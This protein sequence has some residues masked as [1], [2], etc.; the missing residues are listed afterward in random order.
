[1]R[2]LKPDPGELVD[3]QT[4]LELKIKHADSGETE[5]AADEKEVEGG[6]VARTVVK[7]N[8]K[9]DIQ[10]FLWE[11]E[12]IQR[13]MEKNWFPDFPHIGEEYDE[14][15]DSLAEVN[16]RLWDL[17]DEARALRAATKNPA[18][19]NRAGIVLFEI[20]EENDKRAELVKKINALFN[21]HSQEKMYAA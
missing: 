9:V 5:T 7:G 8:S 1:M 2:M 6:A 14:L 3:R 12:E 11:N 16:G 21:I 4:I 17:E 10:P 18:T 20:T 19:M 13:Y 15:F